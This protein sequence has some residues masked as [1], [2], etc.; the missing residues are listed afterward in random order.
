MSCRRKCEAAYWVVNAPHLSMLLWSAAN[1]SRRDTERKTG[2]ATDSSP[3]SRPVHIA[4]RAASGWRYFLGCH[5]IDLDNATDLGC[6][7]A[8]G[9][10]QRINRCR[11]YWFGYRMGLCPYAMAENG[12]RFSKAIR[13]RIH[14]VTNLTPR[15]TPSLPGTFHGFSGGRFI[16]R[17]GDVGDV[18]PLS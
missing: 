18:T 4:L 6:R 3:R 8:G 7:L 11:S 15:T 16:F 1:E 2:M 10:H 14:R 12:G 9:S 5:F 13:G 17:R